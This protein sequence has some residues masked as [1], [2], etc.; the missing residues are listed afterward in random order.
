MGLLP[1]GPS[2]GRQH[3]DLTTLLFRPGLVS[4][5]MLDYQRAGRGDKALDSL[6]MSQDRA[7]VASLRL[8]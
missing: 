3:I 2:R 7:F 1:A 5:H 8:S 4:D 6:L